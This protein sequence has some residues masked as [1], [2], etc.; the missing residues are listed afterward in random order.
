MQTL[1]YELPSPGDG[2]LLKII[3][4][5]EV[6]QHLKKGQMFVISDRIDIGSAETFLT[7]CQTGTGR[8]GDTQKIGLDLHHTRCGQ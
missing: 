6:P 4:D 3:A 8:S 7:G 5:A 2:F 1:G